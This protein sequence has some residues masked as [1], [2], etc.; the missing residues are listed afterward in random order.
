MALSALHSLMFGL[1]A[2]TLQLAA[3]ASIDAQSP[4]L[5]AAELVARISERS[6]VRLSESTV[7][8]F[9]AGRPDTPVTGIAVTMMATLDVLQRSA[10]RG[11]NLIITHE[12]TFYGHRDATDVLEREGDAV[13]SAKLSFIR[14]HGLV[15]WRFHDTPHTMKPDMIRAG[16][17]RALSLEPYQ[18]AKN[19]DVFDIVP[20][21]L[22]ALAR[23]VGR[24]LGAN[25]VR[26]IGD[27]KARVSRLGMTQG[28]P[29]F[30]R[31]RSVL[32]AE[33]I[34]V[35]IMGEDHEWETIEYAA[36][37]ITARQ[38]Q[39]VIVLGHI[40]SEQAGMEEVARWLGTFIK[41]VPIEMVHARDPFRPL[42]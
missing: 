41:D 19:P 27:P 15:V 39:G 5:T 24:K 31:N 9:K 18:N 20:T 13:Y 3:I 34:D 4:R 7:D 36:D 10:A 17:I 37:A 40:P 23:R 1:A 28:F 29:G 30:G 11:H 42:R 22:E 32:Q 14:E 16:M 21:T 38:M 8:T 26:T 12:P 33:G 6:G 25:A 2:A 35:L